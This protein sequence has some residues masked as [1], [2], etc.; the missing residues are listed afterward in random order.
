MQLLKFNFE[1]GKCVQKL[2]QTNS[3]PSCLIAFQIIPKA[4]SAVLSNA[5]WTGA[6]YTICKSFQAN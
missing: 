4:H 5:A 6:Q 3:F 2:V 1:Q